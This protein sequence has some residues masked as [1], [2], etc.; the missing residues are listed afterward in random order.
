[1]DEQKEKNHTFLQLFIEKKRL[2]AIFVDE[3]IL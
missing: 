3:E 2:S 1:M